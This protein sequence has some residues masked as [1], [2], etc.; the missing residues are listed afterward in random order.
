MLHKVVLIATDELRQ[1]IFFKN[2]KNI[3]IVS[4]NEDEIINKIEYLYKNYNMIKKIGKCGRKVVKRNY[5]Y[6]KQIRPRI[7]LINEYL[8]NKEKYE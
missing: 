6:K 1:N 5:S 2:L 4:S 8:K 7:K 3:I